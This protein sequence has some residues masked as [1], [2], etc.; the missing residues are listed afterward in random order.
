VNVK[1][2][3]RVQECGI[4]RYANVR[5]EARV[6]VELGDDI[7]ADVAAGRVTIAVGQAGR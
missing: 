6:G 7:G 1:T 4:A 2:S 5:V 3:Q